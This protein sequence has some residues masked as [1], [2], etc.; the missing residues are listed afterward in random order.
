MPCRGPAPSGRTCTAPCLLLRCSARW[1]TGDERAHA[2]EGGAPEGRERDECVPS[3][4]LPSP[5]CPPRLPMM[6]LSGD[7]DSSS[8]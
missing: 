1:L 5:W 6:H 8:G 4:P 3:P 2:Q 7:L